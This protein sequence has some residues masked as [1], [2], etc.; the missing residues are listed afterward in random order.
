[1]IGSIALNVFHWY[2]QK[3]NKEIT[4]T[5]TKF[6]TKKSKKNKHNNGNAVIFIKNND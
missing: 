3:T 4:K 5:K 1:M 6:N 2:R